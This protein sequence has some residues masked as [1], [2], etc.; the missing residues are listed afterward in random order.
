MLKGTRIQEMTSTQLKIFYGWTLRTLLDRP[1]HILNASY[2]HIYINKVGRF[3]TQK[4][5]LAQSV[6]DFRESVKAGK[7]SKFP[8]KDHQCTCC[9]DR[10]S[11]VAIY[12]ASSGGRS[13][14]KTKK[15]KKL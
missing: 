7:A 3:T 2:A 14:K 9:N 4:S 13:K 8:V 11:A 1:T 10:F 12:L 6:L 5:Y 15:T